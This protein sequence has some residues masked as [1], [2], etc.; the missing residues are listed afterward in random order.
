MELDKVPDG[1]QEDVF[2]EAVLQ[3][4]LY[5]CLVLGLED[6][7][8]FLEKDAHTVERKYLHGLEPDDPVEEQEELL[9]LDVAYE[10]VEHPWEDNPEWLNL[11]LLQLARQLPLSAPQDLLEEG[12]EAYLDAGVLRMESGSEESVFS[13][14]K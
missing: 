8:L 6:G 12:A 9:Y 5:F 4:L 1:F 14:M 11:Q 13:R 10:A 2:L 7:S 3:N